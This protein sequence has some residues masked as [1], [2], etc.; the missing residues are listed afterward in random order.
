MVVVE[1]AKWP[2]NPRIPKMV[3]AIE[4]NDP[5]CEALSNTK[6]NCLPGNFVIQIQEDRGYTFN[7]SLLSF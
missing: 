3:R 6:V 1:A 7:R 5:A 4:R 2:S